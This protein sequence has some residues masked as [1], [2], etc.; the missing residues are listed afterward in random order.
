MLYADFNKKFVLVDSATDLLRY[1]DE[2]QLLLNTVDD[3]SRH[4]LLEQLNIM[5]NNI[6]PST[7]TTDFKDSAVTARDPTMTSNMKR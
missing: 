2:D 4:S 1:F 5:D 7:S 3:S 6:T